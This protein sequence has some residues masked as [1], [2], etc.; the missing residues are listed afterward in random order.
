MDKPL[1]GSIPIQSPWWERGRGREREEES[2]SPPLFSDVS[3][4]EKKIRILWTVFANKYFNW[5][6]QF[7]EQYKLQELIQ[8]E[9]ENINK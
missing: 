7:G 9:K 1:P 5:K 3:D 2:G 8:E 6:G 4:T